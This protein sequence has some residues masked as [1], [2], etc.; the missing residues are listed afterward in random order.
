MAI[1]FAGTLDPDGA[2][3]GCATELLASGLRPRASGRSFMR[4]T[5]S[6]IC[7]NGCEREALH[8]G[9]ATHEVITLVFTKGKPKEL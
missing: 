1:L 5:A 6:T 9:D 4:L 3:Q 8:F 7:R 2:S